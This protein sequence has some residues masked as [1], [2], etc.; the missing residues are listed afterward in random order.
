M[1][2]KTNRCFPNVKVL[3]LLTLSLFWTASPVPAQQ[4]DWEPHKT[5]V[6]VVG[7]LRWKHTEM[8]DSFPQQNRRDAELVAFFKRQGVPAEQI[9]YLRDREAT[10]ARIQTAFST[11][12]SRAG[13]GDM[14][15][16]YY[17]GHGYKTDEGDT[18]LASYDAGDE[19]IPGWSV[20][21]IPVSIE[22]F[23][24]GSRA[25]LAL[26]NCYSGALVEAVSKRASRISYAALTS[27][28]ADQSST[29]EW[30]FTESLLAALRGKAYEDANG[31][32]QITLAELATQVKADMSFA[33]EQR[34]M[35]MTTGDFS[36]LT[37]LSKAEEKSDP[38]IGERVLVRS[39]GDW[40]KGRIIDADPANSQYLIHYYGWDDSYDEWVASR[41]IRQLKV[42]RYAASQSAGFRSDGSR[43]F[44]PRRSGG[45]IASAREN[46]LL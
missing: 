37:V 19:D 26:D 7:T 11:L 6:F 1:H 25:F 22:R 39:E 36:P 15:F 16:L 2:P 10:A 24:K 40:Y 30:T 21:S 46:K 9:V 33:E 35:F 17:T 14:L 43:A 44:L 31:D 18:Y 13:K 4:R 3:L 27:S 5:W 42:K 12:L 8:F 45:Q 28:T 20:N 32:G 41:K 29:S 38:R 34:A 23:F